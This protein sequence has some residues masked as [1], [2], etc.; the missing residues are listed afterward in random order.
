MMRRGVALIGVL[1]AG[2]SVSGRDAQSKPERPIE[3]LRVEIVQTYPH[4]R[5]AFTQGLVFDDGRLLESTGLVGQSSLREVE[6]ATG[7]VIRKIDVPRPIFAEGLALVGD[8][9]IQLTWRTQ[10]AIRY[11]RRSFT[12][13]GEF[14]YQGEGWGI[15]YDGRQLV[16]SNG[17]ADLTVRRPTDFSVTR[18]ITVTMDGR[19]LGDLNELECV[20]GMVY[21]NVWQRDLIVRIDPASGRVTA[22][23]DVPALLSPLERQ[24]VDVLNGIA[25][26]PTSKTYLIT[27]KLWPKLFRVKFVPGV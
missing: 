2:A 14:A 3:R 26:D 7:R 27:G 18:T 9:L 6:L 23:I 5:A 10:L 4:D 15:C 21:A 8:E 13:R 22:R 19:P 12:R 16:M 17:S 25:Y 11:D 24:N 20:D 1:A